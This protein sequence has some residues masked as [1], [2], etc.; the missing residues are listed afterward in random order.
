MAFDGIVTKAI[1]SELSNLVGARIDKIFQPNKNN[2]V[3]G[4]YNQGKNYALNI[5]TE[6]SNCRIHLTTHPNPNPQ[7]APNFCMVLRKN[8]LGL[9]LKNIFTLDLERLVV[10]DFEGFDEVDDLLNKRLIIELMGKHSNI[11]LLD[12]Q[13]IIV[14]SLRHIKQDIEHENVKCRDILPHVRYN[15]P[16]SEKYNFFEVN[17]FNS[18]Y[19]IIKNS[20]SSDNLDNNCTFNFEDVFPSLLANTFNGFSKSFVNNIINKLKLQNKFSIVNYSNNIKDYEHII[21][22]VFSEFKKI[23]DNIGSNNLSFEIIKNADGNPKDYALCI[24]NNVESQFS[25]NFFIDDFYFNKES[26]ENFKNY[27]NSLLKLILNILNKYNKRLLHIN[28]KL[29]DC[30]NMET[31]RVYGELITANLYKFDANSKLDF[32]SVENYYD[33]QKLVKIPLDKRFSINQNAK[34]YFKKYNKLKNALDIVGIQKVE[35]EQD[36]DYIQS[37]VYELENA[38]S[39]E[40]IADIYSEISENVIFKTNSNINNYKSLKNKNSKIKKSKLTKNKKVTFNPIKYTIDDYTVLVGRNNVENDYLTLKYA[41]KSDIWFHV[42]DFHGSHTILKFLNSYNSS[43]YD[44]NSNLLDIIPEDIIL[45]TAKIAA[46]HSKA[47]NSSNVP[48]DFCEVRYVKKP[49]GSK[50]GMVIYTNYRT[51]YV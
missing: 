19:D 43:S 21:F 12:D 48:V 31:F 36:L 9:H 42:K 29:K 17:D 41:N 35:T 4:M 30:D 50:P 2:V 28:Q 16:I 10:I 23:I 6:S 8:L 27:R 22:L 51:V 11:I 40:D 44:K 26:S 46:E 49:S 25:L 14:D 32:I 34:R 5:C 33:E 18:F 20:Y 7:V 1:C 37:V 39:I 24:T 47:K 13:N 15:F 3:I 45:K 38:T